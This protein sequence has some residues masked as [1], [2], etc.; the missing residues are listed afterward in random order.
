[1]NRARDMRYNN[2]NRVYM[3]GEVCIRVC[4]VL[5]LYTSVEKRISNYSAPS[6][7][8]SINPGNKG[9]LIEPYAAVGASLYW[10]V[11][12]VYTSVMGVIIGLSG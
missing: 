6:A 7:N 9:I 2:D 5:C 12:R 8:E 1:M 11:V 4:V 3:S 10:T